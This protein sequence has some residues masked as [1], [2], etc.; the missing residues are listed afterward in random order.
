[1]GNVDCCKAMKTRVSNEAAHGLVNAPQFS[2]WSFFFHI[3]LSL[4][5]FFLHSSSSPI[6]PTL[7]VSFPFTSLLILTSFPRFLSFPFHFIPFFSILRLSHPSSFHSSF[8][9]LTP[10][11]PLCLVSFPFHLFFLPFSPS[12]FTTFLPFYYTPTFTLFFPYSLHTLLTFTS[13]LPLSFLS[14]PFHFSP[15]FSAFFPLSPVLFPL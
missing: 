4:P 15:I 7:A 8:S 9:P 14:F 11:L 3:G 5:S 2:F 6:T 1:M 12:L 10:F 13:L